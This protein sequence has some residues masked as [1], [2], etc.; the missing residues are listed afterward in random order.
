MHQDTKEILTDNR[1]EFRGEV[2]RSLVLHGASIRNTAPHMLQSNGR[3]ENANR[4]IKTVLRRNIAAKDTRPWPDIVDHILVIHRGTP[5]KSTGL[6][7]F[8]LRTNSV[9]CVALP[10]L[11]DE[12]TLLRRT[13][14]STVKDKAQRQKR[15]SP[16]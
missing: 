4:V 2:L 1:A 16:G 3:V 9:A 6:S 11:N 8:Q 13:T 15:S 14:R 12:T 10:S 5:H 7:P